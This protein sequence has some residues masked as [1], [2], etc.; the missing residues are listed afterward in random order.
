MK[1]TY[2]IL[3]YSSTATRVLLFVLLPMVSSA[4][5]AVRDTII[6]D[7]ETIYIEKKEVVTDLDSLQEAAHRDRL[8]SHS[9]RGFPFFVGVYGGA[10]ITNATHA[11]GID[12]FKTLDNF[13]ERSSVNRV[14]SSF[15]AELG[16]S[17]FNAKAGKI[18]FSLQVCSGIGINKIKIGAYA[19]G[20]NEM[21]QDSLIRL[22]K[23]GD[24]LEL[25]YFDSTGFGP[26]GVI[27][28]E[29]RTIKVPVSD[30]DIILNTIDIPIKLRFLFSKES[31]SFKYFLD[32]GIVYRKLSAKTVPNQFLVNSN[33]HYIKLDHEYFDFID[34][35]IVPQIGIGAMR[36]FGQDNSNEDL[37]SRLSVGAAFQAQMQAKKINDYPFF[38][39]SVM[40]FQVCIFVNLKI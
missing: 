10:N 4:S 21:N 12:A 5:W 7:G 29:L 23:M 11:G 19:L 39:Q 35:M 15:G 32:A 17:I 14:N 27:I 24:D 18:D 26:G 22:S 30:N 25:L 16:Y 37:L 1:I 28:G 33:G 6:L 31:S 36:C 34:Y 38:N 8:K 9:E 3:Q 2:L 40:S 20:E 13:M